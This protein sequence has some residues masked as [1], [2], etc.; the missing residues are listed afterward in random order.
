MAVTSRTH[1]EWLLVLIAMQACPLPGKQAI[2][3]VGLYCAR[4]QTVYKTKAQ[5]LQLWARIG[6]APC[7]A[8]HGRDIWTKIIAGQSRACMSKICRF[9][10]HA[11]GEVRHGQ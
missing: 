5:P 2:P 1:A 6:A 4:S 3:V 9:E 7:H 11:G 10:F 8:W